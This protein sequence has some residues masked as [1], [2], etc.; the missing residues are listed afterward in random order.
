MGQAKKRGSREQ[1]VQEAKAAGRT[2]GRVGPSKGELRRAQALA[3]VALP[4]A[5]ERPDIPPGYVE[6]INEMVL[7]VRK[8]LIAH[9]GEH[10]I[11]CLPP[12]EVGVIA[13]LPQLLD[14]VARNDAARAVATALVEAFEP[15]KT[16][17]LFM[18]RAAL[19]F[20]GCPA[21]LVAP[22]DYFTDGATLVPMQ[23]GGDA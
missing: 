5:G 11:F 19:E 21:E 17:T 13:E 10:P 7:V 3:A 15:E 12:R 6:Q 22:L 23:R 1:R 4:R 20:A 2:T 8:W 9:P 18:L 14:R 16:P